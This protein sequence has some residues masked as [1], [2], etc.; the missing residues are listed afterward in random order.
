[1]YFIQAFFMVKETIQTLQS[2]R[3][4]LEHVL[5]ATNNFI[6]WANNEFHERKFNYKIE[7][8]SKVGRQSKIKKKRFFDEV[9][10]DEA[11]RSKREIQ[12]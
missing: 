2:Q 3:R 11:I 6:N 4:N 9:T 10:E 1:M 8:Y 7:K 5:E 12:D